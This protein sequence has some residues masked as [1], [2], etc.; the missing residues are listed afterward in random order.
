MINKDRL[1]RRFSRNA[2]QYDKHA[3]VQKVM[4]DTLIENIKRDGKYFKNILEI[5]CGTGYVTKALV[6]Y[7]PGAQIT[8]VDI[9][10]GMIEHISSTLQDENVKF[11]CGDIE[12]MTLSE[13]Y[14][15]VISNATFQWFNHL[16]ETLDKIVR[17]LNPNGILCFS[18]FGEKT[19]YELHRTFDKAGEILKINE[20]VSPGQS[21]YSLNELEGICRNIAVKEGRQAMEI[22]SFQTYE[23]EYFNSCK[24]FLYSIKKIGA[25]NSESDRNRIVPDFIEKV[26]EIYDK[27]YLEDNKV[28]A[29]YHNLFIYMKSNLRGLPN[30]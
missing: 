17:S 23:L 18:T 19:F 30:R 11:I 25:N 7:F 13:K 24:D 29:T 26:M 27:D 9:A 3:R 21:F 16:D 20:E 14:D 8:G 22:C 28:R 12:E 1:K 4:G 15:L 6:K 10:P 2:K 5:G